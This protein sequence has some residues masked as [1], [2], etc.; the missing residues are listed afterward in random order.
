MLYAG[1]MKTAHKSK[2]KKLGLGMETVRIFRVKSGLL[3]GMKNQTNS[4][5]HCP[6]GGGGG[7]GSNPNSLVY[8]CG[9]CFFP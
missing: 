7:G 2:A 6:G 1:R 5:L 8:T 9:I 4:C 3:T